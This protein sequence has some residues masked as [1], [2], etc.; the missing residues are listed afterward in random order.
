MHPMY[1]NI[2]RFNIGYFEEDD[3]PQ[4]PEYTCIADLFRDLLP[5]FTSRIA[6]EASDSPG[7][8]FCFYHE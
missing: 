4:E 6:P 1:A 2:H 3:L 5:Q 7:E 8:C